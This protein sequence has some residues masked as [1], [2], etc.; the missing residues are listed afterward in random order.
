MCIL[1][2]PDC[3]KS[4]LLLVILVCLIGCN[5]R[6]DISGADLLFDKYY[7]AY[8]MR[9]FKD[10]D[11]HQVDSLINVYAEADSMTRV[12]ACH[13]MKGK[14]S[15][16]EKDATTAM[17]EFIKAGEYITDDDSIVYEYYHNMAITLYP[18]N[19][20]EARYYLNR[21][22]DYADRNDNIHAEIYANS[23]AVLLLD[24]IDS[25]NVCRL[26]NVE[27]CNRVG[28]TIELYYT[29][30][31]FAVRFYDRLPA[32]SAVALILPR[33][34]SI[35]YAGDA[36]DIATV[37]LTALEC[38]KALPYIKK[39][40]H[41]PYFKNEY[42]YYMAIYYANMGK[43]ESALEMY[44]AAYRG[45]IS[46][47]NEIFN[48]EVSELNA[49][50]NREKAEY[51]KQIGMGQ[52]RDA[53][54]VVLICCLG[55]IALALTVLIMFQQ[56]KLHRQKSAMEVGMARLKQMELEKKHT[57]L[58]KNNESLKSDYQ[59]LQVANEDMKRRNVTER[60]NHIAVSESYKDILVMAIREN[61]SLIFLIGRQLRERM[62]DISTQLNETDL[63][64]LFAAYIG[65]DTDEACQ[66][67]NVSYGTWQVRMNR[68]RNK[69][70]LAAR[71]KMP[72]IL[73]SVFV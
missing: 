64:Y 43:L 13:L 22:C 23:V 38:E 62:D 68:L 9:R 72:D 69:L 24:D 30:A 51:E 31:K 4:G 59:N 47:Q 28:D 45:F 12:G 52:V 37:Y 41:H 39:L 6:P 40:E 63:A 53:R 3:K 21:L 34:E 1:K 15:L 50:F 19:K 55:I 66:I 71:T 5:G 8:R 60:R 10:I 70:S 58:L 61:H 49:S 73:A 46:A 44:D 7:A 18:E 56:M 48:T 42:H 11:L 29:N 17:D 57:E 27:L 65:F 54:R 26:R 16:N 35:G 32:D 36:M 67:L 2:I 25:A 33:Y 14:V 20:E